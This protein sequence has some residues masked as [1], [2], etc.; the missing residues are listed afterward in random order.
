M[1][2]KEM[3]KTTLALMRGLN[4]N[5]KAKADDF[6][7]KQLI[8]H[9]KFKNAQTIGLV[10]SMPHEVQTD[11]IIQYALNQ[12]KSIYV[13]STNYETHQMQFQKLEDLNQVALDCKSIRYVN[14]NTPITDHL[15]LVIVPGVV[16]N[17]AGYRIGYGGGYFDEFLS[18]HQPSTISLVY[19]IQ[20]SDQIPVEPHDYPVQEL[21]I[22]KTQKDGGNI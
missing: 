15:D 12:Q 7:F 14:A 3:R 2:K 8:E 16:F 10:L 4:D 1:S 19:D 5:L 6:L 13:P 11:Q 20:L 22:A 17:H 9:D 18:K 21:I